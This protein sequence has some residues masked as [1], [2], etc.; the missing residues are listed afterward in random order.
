MEQWGVSN[1]IKAICFDTAATNTG[2]HHGAGV[3]LEKILKRK[4]IWLPC[5]HHVIELVIKGVFEAYWPVQS[6]PNVPF[7]N[8]F[9]IGWNKIN[10]SKYNAGINDKIV[11]N[12]LLNKKDELLSFIDNY[13]QKFLPRNDY[14]EFL[15]Y[16]LFSW[17]LRQRIITLLNVREQ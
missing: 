9:K 14:R 4:L 7:F 13:S 12:I 10:T 1:Y 3:E 5:R 17:E 8:R 2:I 6:G 16:H 11:A 15:S